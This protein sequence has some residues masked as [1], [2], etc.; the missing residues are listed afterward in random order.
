MITLYIGLKEKEAKSIT[1][2]LKLI[3]AFKICQLIKTFPWTEHLFCP[4]CFCVIWRHLV[5]LDRSCCSDLSGHWSE[6]S[7]SEINFPDCPDTTWMQHYPCSLRLSVTHIK[8]LT[9][10]C[11]EVVCGTS[12][13]MTLGHRG[14]SEAPLIALHAHTR[15]TL[16]HYTWPASRSTL[17]TNH[18]SLLGTA[19]TGRRIRAN[20]T[21]W[22][23]ITSR[24]TTGNIKVLL[25]ERREERRRQKE[26]QWGECRG[27]EAET[28]MELTGDG[29]KLYPT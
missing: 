9:S 26:T 3:N 29:N 18:C 2:N 25:N 10:S 15:D 12:S 24:K 19:G 11:D 20:A 28:H 23:T 13:R 7:Q 17:L 22:G 27:E 5:K 16:F 4:P 6:F 8:L 14:P 21:K 1:N